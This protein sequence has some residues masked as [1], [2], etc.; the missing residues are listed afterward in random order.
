MDLKN[1]LITL[2]SS[3]GVGYMDTVA[4]IA[5]RQLSSFSKVT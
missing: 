5:A 3:E 4:D 1:L 2:A